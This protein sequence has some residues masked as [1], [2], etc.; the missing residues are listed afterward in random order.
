VDVV[1]PKGMLKN[2]AVLGP[3]RKS[4]QIEISLTDSRKLGV[5]GFIRESG[6]LKETVGCT[7]VGPVGEYSVKEGLIIAKRHVHM[8]PEDAKK[9]GIKDGQLGKVKVMSHGRSLV[10]DDVAMRVN[11]NFSLAMHV[12]TDEA[13]ALNYHNGLTG[14]III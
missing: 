2:V 8:S 5:E 9:L 6:D 12:D 14:E 13:N 4:T 3:A 11:K 1:G 10:Y 7:L